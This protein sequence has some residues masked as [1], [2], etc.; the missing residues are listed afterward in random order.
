MPLFRRTD[1]A[2]REFLTRTTRRHVQQLARDSGDG[3]AG[4]AVATWGFINGTLTNQT[5]LKAL[6]DDLEALAFLEGA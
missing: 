6:T 4:G 5:D 2:D 1:I 3:P